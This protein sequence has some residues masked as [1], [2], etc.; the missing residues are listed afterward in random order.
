MKRTLS[1]LAVLLGVSAYGST[2]RADL[3]LQAVGLIG[4]GVDTG[5]APNN[6]YALQIGGA[7]ELIVSGYVLG[8]RATRSV[9]TNDDCIN[10]GRSVDDLRTLGADLGFEWELAMLHLGPR[11]GVGY[12]AER[13]D[14]LRATYL[15]PGAVAELEFGIFVV[16]ADVRYR[17]VVNDTIAN[18]LLAHARLGLRF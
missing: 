8:I 11:F 14:G 17:V 7:A 18:G 15:E 5:D 1:L 10:C 16:G 13:N 9:G 3:D 4:S 2:A 6:P 12:I